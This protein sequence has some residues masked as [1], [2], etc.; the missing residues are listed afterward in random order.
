MSK[1]KQKESRKERRVTR[2]T[3]REMDRIK[4]Q[5]PSLWWG[6]KSKQEK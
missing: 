4:K 5:S 1:T 6:I 2:K 3:Q